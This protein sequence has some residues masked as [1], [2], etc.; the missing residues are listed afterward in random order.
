MSP[1]LAGLIGSIPLSYFTGSLSVGLALR[2][3]GL[4]KTPEESRPSPELTELA[5]G[6]NARRREPRPLSE[7]AVNYGLCFPG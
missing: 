7:L 4:F 6:L 1:I 2:R 3:K 5:A